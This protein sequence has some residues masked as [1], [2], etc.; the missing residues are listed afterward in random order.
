M[1]YLI[2]S[3]IHNDREGYEKLT[4]VSD[5]ASA[6]KICLGDILNAHQ[7]I[8]EEFFHRVRKDA[9]YVVM[10][11]HEAVLINR[12]GPEV[13]NE[14]LYADIDANRQ[15]VMAHHQYLVQELQNLQQVLVLDDVAFTHGSFDKDTPWR[16][17]RYIEDVQAEQPYATHKINFLGHGHIPFIAWFEDGLWFY[18]RQIYNKTFELKRDIRYII[19]CGSVLGSRE[20][21]WHEKTYVLFDP[22]RQIITFH[23]LA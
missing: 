16:H 7:Q 5:F 18:E 11:N 4:A 2:F 23:N 10:G 12:C 13:F 19:N 3:D 22:E 9:D 8:D 15:N 20:M 14:N 1:S 21:R 17:V 6:A